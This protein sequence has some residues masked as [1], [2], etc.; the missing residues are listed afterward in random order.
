VKSVGSPP[1]AD[2]NESE[3]GL[4]DSNNEKSA[5]RLSRLNIQYA[6]SHLQR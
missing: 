4:E 6:D 3:K 2:R 5:I 1:L